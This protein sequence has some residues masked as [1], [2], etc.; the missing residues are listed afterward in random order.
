[1]P[2]A[3]MTEVIDT[4]KPTVLTKVKNTLK[5]YLLLNVLVPEGHE[6]SSDVF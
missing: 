2:T 3:S 5:A 4:E 6:E 1:M